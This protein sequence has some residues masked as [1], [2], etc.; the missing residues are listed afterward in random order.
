MAKIK[1]F[2]C[3]T[4]FHEELAKKVYTEDGKPVHV[5]TGCFMEIEYADADGI[6]MVPGGP[7]LWKHREDIP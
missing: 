6:R 7:K 3:G 5:G 1:C 2:A 4:L